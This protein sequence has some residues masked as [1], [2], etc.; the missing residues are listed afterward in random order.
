MDEVCSVI[1]IELAKEFI[2]FIRQIEP[3]WNRAFFRFCSEG[4]KYGSNGS[5]IYDSKVMLIDPFKY[6]DFFA[7]M[8]EKSV[9]LL[10]LLGKEQ[11]VLLLIIDSGFN[12]DIK[13][14]YQNLE[15]WRIAK[16]NGGIGV[17]EGI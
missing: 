2:E 9:R 4:F 17:P 6:N 15:R 8:N 5:Y 10:T 12:Y 1:V 7:K 14:E 3:A 13:F 16:V 11:G